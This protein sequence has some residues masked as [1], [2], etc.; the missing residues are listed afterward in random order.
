MGIQLCG[1][2]VGVGGALW[3]ADAAV[4]PYSLGASPVVPTSRD[5]LGETLQSRDAHKA[6]QAVGWVLK[7]QHEV[8]TPTAH[9][10]SA[11]HR[12]AMTSY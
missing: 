6:G 3:A 9:L 12:S 8:I 1:T 10:I 2:Y 11:Y 7:W 5:E 4:M